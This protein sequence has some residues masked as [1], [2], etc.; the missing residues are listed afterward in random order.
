[1]NVGPAPESGRVTDVNVVVK[2]PNPKASIGVVLNNRANKSLCLLELTA[3]KNTLLFCL[4]GD[5]RR[6]IASVPNVAKLDGSDRIRVVELPGAA[7]FIVNGQKIGDVRD[8]PA[9]GSQ[10]GIMAYDV[11]TFGIA[12]FAVTAGEADAAGAG[13]GRPAR[14]RW[15]RWERRQR[16][17]RRGGQPAQAARRR[18]FAL[19]G[20][21]PVSALRRRQ[22]AYRVGVRRHHAQHLPARVRPRA[23]RRT[24]AALDRR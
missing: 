6:D 18:R 24:G 15:W 16:R 13:R 11:G 17:W 2:S 21:G 22:H 8:E 5:K 1:M 12:D 14:A 10:I 7:R 9:T 23:D 19:T 4:Q 20:R 3:D